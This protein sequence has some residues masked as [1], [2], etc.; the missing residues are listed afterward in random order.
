[1]YNHGFALAASVPLVLRSRSALIWPLPCQFTLMASSSRPK[2][3][4]IGS[5]RLH[6]RIPLMQRLTAD[7]FEVAA[8]GPDKAEEFDEA[9]DLS[10]IRDIA[11]QDE[12]DRPEE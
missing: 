8:V 10:G 7:G 11:S 5:G 3:W 4:I 12:D 9:D 6:L 1:M 2:I